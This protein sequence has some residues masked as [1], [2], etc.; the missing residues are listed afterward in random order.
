MSRHSQRRGPLRKIIEVSRRG[1]GIF[2][3]D[4]V[5]LECGHETYSNGQYKA[6]CQWCQEVIDNLRPAEEFPR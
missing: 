1:T 5:R 6:R 4:R 2:D 3:R